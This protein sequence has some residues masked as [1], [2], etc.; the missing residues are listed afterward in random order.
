[1]STY[2]SAPLP[3]LDLAESSTI[4]V[5]TLDNLAKIVSVAI[6]FRQDTPA[7][8]LEAAGLP[9]LFSYVPTPVPA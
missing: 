9:P 3:D 6:H 7:A 1:M 4:T 5:D 2:L 8:L